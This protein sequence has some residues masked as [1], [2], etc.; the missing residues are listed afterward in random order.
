MGRMLSFGRAAYQAIVPRPA[1]EIAHAGAVRLATVVL[2][3]SKPLRIRCPHYTVFVNPRDRAG[4]EMWLSQRFKNNL[5]HEEF[6]RQVFRELVAANPGCAIID[7]GA[8]YGLYT[9]L[10]CSEFDESHVPRI[11]AIE[12]EHET[13]RHLTLS[14]KENRFEERVQTINAAVVEE[15]GKEC[16]FWTHSTLRDGTMAQLSKVVE[17]GHDYYYPTRKIAGVAL[18]VLWKDDRIGWND[19]VIVKIDIEG[20]EPA[21][22][23]GMRELINQAHRLA[24]LIEFNPPVLIESGNLNRFIDQLDEINADHV[25]EVDPAEDF[26]RRVSGRDGYQKIVDRVSGRENRFHWH[27]NILICRNME[28]AGVL[29]LA[30][31]A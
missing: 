28:L 29:G 7:V 24:I 15:H 6:E 30:R 4:L 12:A 3:K 1:R 11:V 8:S 17:P 22:L 16:H 26:V 23:E 19:S 13:F 18:D 9:L 25:L 14:L 27:S 31:G 2:G 21:A 10:V 20:G 5:G